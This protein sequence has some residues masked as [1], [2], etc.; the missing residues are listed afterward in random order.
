MSAPLVHSTGTEVAGSGDITVSWPDHATN[1][2]GVL[3]VETA[4]QAVSTPAGWTL[5]GS[6]G[7]GTAGA[8]AATKI[9]GY[10]KRAASAAEAS[11]VVADTGT[12]QTGVIIVFRG[13]ITSGSPLDGGSGT[14]GSGTAVS[15]PS[16]TTT[17]ND[18]M[19]VNVLSTALGVDAPTVQPNSLLNGSLTNL[20]KRFNSQA[21]GVGGVGGTDTSLPVGLMSFG[22][23]GSFGDVGEAADLSTTPPLCT[24]CHYVP[25]TSTLGAQI[26]VA[27]QK[28]ITLMLILAGNKQSFSTTVNGTVTLD[29]AK[30]ESN[31][32]KFRPDADNTAFPDRLK[33][34]DAIRRRR[35]VVYVVDEPYLTQNFNSSIPNITPTQAN[36]MGLLVKSIWQGYSPITVVRADAEKMAGGWLGLGVPSTGWSGFDYCVSQYELKY[37]KGGPASGSWFAG[38]HPTTFLQTHRQII[39]DNNLNL[40][41][42]PILNIWGGGIGVDTAGVTAAWDTDGPGGGSTLGW[43]RGIQ[44]PSEAQV[45]T[46]L[47]QTCKCVMANPA[48]IMKW[49]DLMAV[50]TDIPLFFMWQHSTSTNPASSFLTFYQRSDVQ[51][52]IDYAITTGAARTSFTGWRTAK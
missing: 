49:A 41:I 45:M 33:L 11:V 35:A 4:N 39:A 1:D 37:A 17:V 30:F 21:D 7:S 31:L 25:N 22:S 14:S 38:I 28:G 42:I 29:M 6:G 34:A 8:A 3:L 18:D 51:S 12:R 40:G 19:V 26:D 2:I 47:D 52:A 27:D 10:W 50:E 5:I 16:I 20:V 32:R 24:A 23:G 15:F 13:C 48:W 46:T 36:Q 9:F 43:V 44:Q